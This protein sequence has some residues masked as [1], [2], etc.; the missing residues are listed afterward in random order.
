MILEIYKAM[1]ETAQTIEVPKYI[2]L[3]YHI[4]EEQSAEFWANKSLKKEHGLLLEEWN[5][6]G[7]S[8]Y[9]KTLYGIKFAIQF[10]YSKLN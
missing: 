8:R 9:K 3:T 5:S 4:D 1:L 2:E 6:E 7:K 10:N